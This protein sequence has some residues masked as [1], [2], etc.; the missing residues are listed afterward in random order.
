M[1]KYR[2]RQDSP[3]YYINGALCF[4]LVLACVYIAYIEMWLIIG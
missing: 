4:M 2:V 1:K 3:L